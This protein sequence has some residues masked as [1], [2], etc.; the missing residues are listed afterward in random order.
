VGFVLIQ[1]FNSPYKADSITDFWR[2]WHISLSSWLRDY[3]YIPLGGNRLG[4]ART[5]VN[6][7]VVMLIG[8]LWH[9]ANW[10]FVVW[11]A[12]HGGM[13]AFERL[14]GKT[15]AY[16][17]LPRVLRTA[18]TFAIVCLAWVFFRADTI[19][20]AGR[21]LKCLVGLEPV[22]AGQSLAMAPV[23]TSLHAV[24][25]ATA[26]LLVW[27]APNSWAMSR[28]ITPAL[29][30]FMLGLIYTSVLFMWTQ[31]ENPFIYFQF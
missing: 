1:N 25:F 10:T 29:A 21:Y 5:Y 4:P 20:Q 24:V 17:F 19:Q 15:A 23:Y 8:G 14:I 16:A 3:L 22:S 18:V 27:G 30:A 31:T 9:G 11:G 26:G 28:R 7:L 6:L 2:R 13:L 12:I